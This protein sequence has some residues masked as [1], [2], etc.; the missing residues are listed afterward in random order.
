MVPGAN[1]VGAT[2]DR[3][4]KVGPED[5]PAEPHNLYTGIVRDGLGTGSKRV[6]EPG[7]SIP[8]NGTAKIE[9]GATLVM[10]DTR[11]LAIHLAEDTAKTREGKSEDENGC[12]ETYI[13]IKLPPPL[14]ELLSA[15]VSHKV[16]IDAIGDIENKLP[17]TG[18]GIHV[19]LPKNT[20]VPG[21]EKLG[22]DHCTYG[23]DEHISALE[24]EEV[25]Y[26]HTEVTKNSSVTQLE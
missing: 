17:A 20:T 15:E 19:K 6:D 13:I 26:A 16:H 3:S 12:T 4:V 1:V 23:V 2:P 24:A 8:R 10:T 22:A 5:D 9:D 18:G 7:E 11:P 14:K 21:L 25:A